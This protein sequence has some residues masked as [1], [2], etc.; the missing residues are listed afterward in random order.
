M[1]EMQWDNE[2]R[3]ARFRKEA[4][5]AFQSYSFRKFSKEERRPSV[6]SGDGMHENGVHL[7]P[8]LLLAPV[9]VLWAEADGFVLLDG[10]V[11]TEGR[12][13]LLRPLMRRSATMYSG[14]R[15]GA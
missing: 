10:I 2:P 9:G 8:D 1:H 7:L 4:G 5:S 15:S 14:V 13:Q 12:E 11:E 6:A 3:G